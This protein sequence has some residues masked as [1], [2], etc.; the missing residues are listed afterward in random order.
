MRNNFIGGGSFR[1]PPPPFT[2]FIWNIDWCSTLDTLL[3][4]I[5]QEP[6]V[7]INSISFIMV[8]FWFIWIN[9][10]LSTVIYLHRS[11]GNQK[12]NDVGWGGE[13]APPSNSQ[14][15]FYISLPWLDLTG[16]GNCAEDYV[17]F[18]MLGSFF[19]PYLCLLI[20][21][22]FILLDIWHFIVCVAS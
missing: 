2:H 3:S 14:G 8:A 13:T 7:S 20:V 12:L 9:V 17:Y 5:R 16:S 6:A 22:C 4:S 1:G 11:W 19:S 18:G 15:L 10:E 21:P